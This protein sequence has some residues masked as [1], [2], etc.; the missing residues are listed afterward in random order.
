MLI[1]FIVSLF[2]ADSFADNVHVKGYYR[3]DG[4][5]V[6]PHYRSAPNSTT[7]DNWSTIGNVN[8]HTGKIGTKIPNDVIV[9]GS[10]PSVSFVPSHPLSEVLPTA[11]TCQSIM[12][13]WLRRSLAVGLSPS[14]ED[15]ARMKAW[16]STKCGTKTSS[17]T[18]NRSE[19]LRKF[20]YCLYL[21]ARSELVEINDAMKCNAGQE[22]EMKKCLL[23]RSTGG[24]VYLTDASQCWLD[25]HQ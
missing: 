23:V 16:A 11:P 7:S 10:L 4:T 24:F 25:A 12:D 9:P 21:P 20:E 14:A 2:C 1:T 6:E 18:T 3:A 22:F 17:I 5:Y 13:E 15:V 19:D 8:P